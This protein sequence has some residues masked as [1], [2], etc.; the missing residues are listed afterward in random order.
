M[1]RQFDLDDG[2][3]AA[4]EMLASVDAREKT[5]LLMVLL[6]KGDEIKKPSHFIT[7]SRAPLRKTPH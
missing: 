6:S 5:R 7:R 4:L 3:I 2:A 1:V